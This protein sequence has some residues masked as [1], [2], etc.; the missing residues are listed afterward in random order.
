MMVDDVMM[1]DAA[2]ES[3]A[4]EKSA[5]AVW[6]AWDDFSETNIQVEGVDESDIIKTDGK[7]IYYYNQNKQ[8]IYIVKVGTL[9]VVKK[10]NLPKNF[11]S[12]VLYIWEDR[13]VVLVSGYS[14]TDYS[15]RGYWINRNSKTY[16]IVFDTS[17][18][19]NPQLIKLYVSDGNLTKS[20][21]IG[22]HLYVLSNN[23]FN[24]PYYNFKTEDD[25]DVTID[26]IM[27]KQIDISKTS[28]SSKQ[29]LTVK[30]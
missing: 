22:N 18:V 6:W 13:L 14:Q 11:Y 12:P 19:T 15:K 2:V 5:D 3:T 9:E 26:T 21:K 23:Y 7:H 8:S 24:I 30:W 17:D 1:E 4:V 16:T 20:R 29:N 25:I 10:I 27:P 28:D